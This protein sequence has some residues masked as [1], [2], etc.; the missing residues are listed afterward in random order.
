MEVLA[1]ASPQDG[2]RYVAIPALFLRLMQ[3]VQDNAL[4]ASQS[5]ANVRNVVEAL[6][7]LEKRLGQNEKQKIPQGCFNCWILIKPQR[8]AS[9]KTINSRW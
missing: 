3:N 6:S 7:H 1:H 5:I 9:K 8:I 4:L 2:R